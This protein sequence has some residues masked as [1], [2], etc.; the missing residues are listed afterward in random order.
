MTVVV[1]KPS[2][3]EIKEEVKAMREASSKLLA[4]RKSARE[5]LV[6]HGFITPSG[7]LSRTYKK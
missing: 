5:Y 1:A 7:R 6:S 2:Q 3:A 4:S